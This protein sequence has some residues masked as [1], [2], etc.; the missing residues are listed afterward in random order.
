LSVKLPPTP[1][2]TAR[3]S[4]PTATVSLVTNRPLSLKTKTL[5]TR[6]VALKRPFVIR[7]GLSFPLSVFA[8]YRP[9][10]AVFP[11]LE[12]CSSIRAP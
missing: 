4:R 10:V 7:N 8:Q 3:G 2:Q 6:F 5:P 9:A 11:L 12:T 1:S